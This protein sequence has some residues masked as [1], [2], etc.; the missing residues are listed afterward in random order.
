MSDTP[1]VRD[2]LSFTVTET[3]VKKTGV[4]VRK[5]ITD[6]NGNLIDL[7]VDEGSSVV[8]IDVPTWPWEEP[9]R[10]LV[11]YNEW[12]ILEEQPAPP[13]PEVVDDPEVWAEGRD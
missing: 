1:E 5:T 9:C 13:P 3:Y 4:M 2:N 6:L 10:E 7:P 12:R 8:F 11:P